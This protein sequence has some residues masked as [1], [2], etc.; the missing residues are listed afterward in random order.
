[1]TVRVWG[2]QYWPPGPNSRPLAE[3]DQEREDGTRA[4]DCR[5][6]VGPDPE[7]PW[8]ASE[9]LFCGEAAE[10]GPYCPYH[11]AKASGGRPKP[12]QDE[13]L[14]AILRARRAA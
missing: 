10:D 7:A 14:I 11:K 5:F 9:Q 12:A 4:H 1:M 8:T 3:L 2:T 13:A 6:P